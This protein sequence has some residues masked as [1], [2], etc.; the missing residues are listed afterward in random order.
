MRQIR[1]TSPGIRPTG[2]HPETIVKLAT[3]FAAAAALVLTACE[4]PV[5]PPLGRAPA[6]SAPTRSVGTETAVHLASTFC[7]YG[8]GEGG[9]FCSL[10]VRSTGVPYP[11][12]EWNNLT[13]YGLLDSP[14][15]SPDATRIAFTDG[16]EVQMVS[17]IDGRRTNLTNHPAVDASPAWSPNGAK[18]VFLSDRDGAAELYVM[19][20]DGSNVVRLTYNVG[21][22]PSVPDPDWA[23]DGSRIIFTCEVESGN[24]DICRINADGTGL[25]RLTSEPTPEFGPAWSPNGSR[26]AF[27]SGSQLKLMNADGSGATQVATASWRPQA[28]D[29]SPDGTRLAF[30]GTYTGGTGCPADGIGCP[31]D[32]MIMNVDGTALQAFSTGWAPAWAPVAP[33]LPVDQPPV[34]RFTY[35]CSGLTCSFDA[36]GSTDDR[37]T[38]AS[39]S[40]TFGDGTS[41]S[42]QGQ[43]TYAAVGTY[44]VTL[45][46]TDGAGQSASTSQTITVTPPPDLPPVA[47][48]GVSCAGLAC[49]F[50]SA[51]SS[52][53]VGIASR[54]WTF[55]DGSTAGNVIVPAKTFAT[56]GTY[57][58]TLTV[59]DTKGQSASRSQS[60]GVTDA[61]PIARFT[62]SCA[63]TVCTFDGRSSTDE[64]S[65][66]SYSWD[67]GAASGKPATGSIVSF[68][69][70]RGGTFNVRLTVRDPGGQTNSV[71]Q[72]ITVQK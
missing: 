68:D 32:I 61:P 38:L 20:A 63:R 9:Y 49:T 71:T 15:W 35:W 4:N 64:L 59:T 3:I 19:N 8:W 51:G 28:P 21:V 37:R 67:F 41:S 69:Y 40:W 33:S 14:T 48:F 66:T 30:Q 17:L 42:P 60:V 7:V 13:G 47:N 6:A 62:A 65:I 24:A 31:D 34:P 44:T 16:S 18:I 23:P 56:P 70:K 5:Q 29:W 57:T 12:A 53:D 1:E 58:V 10:T 11:A 2:R 36:S 46:V 26:I 52:D 27:V 50:N 22:D 43:H 45:T 55:G 54:S 39:S 72:S 25:V